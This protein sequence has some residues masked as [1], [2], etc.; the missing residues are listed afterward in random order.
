M[1]SRSVCPLP[2]PARI[3]RQPA[4]RA[5]RHDAISFPCLPEQ[6]AQGVVSQARQ[7]LKP[8]TPEYGDRNPQVKTEERKAVKTARAKKRFESSKPIRKRNNKRAV[9]KLER[10][11]QRDFADGMNYYCLTV[12]K[13]ARFRHFIK[14]AFTY[15]HAVE[16]MRSIM[17]IVRKRSQSLEYLY[18][19]E[20]ETSGTFTVH[21]VTNAPVQLLREVSRTESGSAIIHVSYYRFTPENRKELV[22]RVRTFTD[23][24]TWRDNHLKG[25]RLFCRNKHERPASILA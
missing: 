13:S 23:N 3:W 22:E 19:I 16:Y 7:H 5:S 15:D 24:G 2:Y 14:G 18:I 6:R 9:E 21:L 10:Y 25:K 8:F 4:I 17:R 1:Q 11:L 12:G 20:P